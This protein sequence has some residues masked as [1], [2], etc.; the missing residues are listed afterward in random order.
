[1]QDESTTPTFDYDVFIS[2]SRKDKSFVD[3]LVGLL[4]GLGLRCFRDIVRLQPYDKLDATLKSS[5]ARSRYLIAT[6]SPAYL[7][8]YW[9]LFEAMEALQGQDLDLRFLPLVVR[10]SPQDQ[11]LDESFVMS[12][13][14]DI[15]EQM[16]L[17]ELQMV[18]M[19]AYDL[20][21]KLEKLQFV[22][23]H[24]PRVFVK[25][26]ERL[27]PQFDLWDDVSSRRTIEQLVSKLAPDAKFDAS[28][29][30]LTYQKLEATPTVVPRL[31][32]LPV[33][34]WKAKVGC[35]AWRNSP[36][37]V[38]NKVFISTAGNQWNSNDSA[39]GIYCLDAETGR[40]EWFHHTNSDA[41]SVLVSKGLVVSGCDEGLLVAVSA[42][43]GEHRWSVK[44]DSGVVGGPVKLSA[45]IGGSLATPQ[46]EEL[47]DPLLVVT[48]VGSIYLID[49][50][51]GVVIEQIS[52]GSCVNAQPLMVTE[53]ASTKFVIPT[54]D[55]QLAFVVY[56]DIFISLR[57]TGR[58][59]IQIADSWSK[60]GRS[61]PYLSVRPILR[62]KL[63]IQGFARDTYY[64]APPL[65]AIDLDSHSVQWEASNTGAVID[66]FGNLR[67]SPIIVND[68]IIFA[69]A[70][71]KHLCAL[72]PASGQLLWN[73]ELGQEMFEQWSGPVASGENVFIGCHD[74]Y[75]HKVNAKDR[76][77]EWSLFLGRSIDSGVSISSSQKL[78]E[79]ESSHAHLSGNN[80]PILATPVI[81]RGRLYVG[82]HE[83]YLYCVANL[84]I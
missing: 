21:P 77:R 29:V 37:I 22:R 75:L 19:K 8:S 65:V 42:L 4:N 58:L 83:G 10:Y 69:A 32:E 15:D 53:R 24:L 36:V 3:F 62:D 23:G 73:I 52:L 30:R 84:G 78:P 55:G 9:C 43:N 54:I 18:K 11:S 60:T 27:Y 12:A 68:E 7:R 13:L 76:Q 16:K 5:I 48:Y 81:D 17:F 47:R 41:N 61:S 33:V 34:H 56:S 74:G 31:N 63:V 1:M 6:I 39:D 51:T 66:H 28:L 14:Q 71:S 25:M 79:F 64:Q 20:A 40:Q 38:G 82:T 44:L 49:L 67:G 26:H 2:Y 57:E 45:N 70:Y 35:F 46:E 50:V 80:S 59:Q 72:S